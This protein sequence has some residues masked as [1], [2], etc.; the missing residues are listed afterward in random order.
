M[1]RLLI[2]FLV[3]A[4]G[5]L[6][7]MAADPSEQFLSAYQSYQ[8][9]EKAERDGNTTDALK[10]Y[11]YAESLLADIAAKDPSWQKAVV[12]YRLK[13]TRDG[14]T[15]LQGEPDAT[16]SSKGQEAMETRN[17]S[18]MTPP[19]SVPPEASP[20]PSP[21]G[22]SITILAPGAS[23]SQPQSSAESPSEVRR[24]K[25]QI[26]GLQSELLM[27]K[28]A[29]GSE[30]SRSRDLDKAK[31]VEERSGLE[32]ELLAAKDQI[33][34]L[35]EKLHARDSWDKDLKNL[36]KKLDEAVADS[37]VAD[38]LNQQREKA[39]AENTARLVGELSEANRKVAEAGGVQRNFLEMSK[40][41]ESDR[42][43]LKQ[44]QA[45]LD[46]TLQTAKDSADKNSNL[47]RQISEMSEKLAIAEKKS[48]DLNLLR[49]KVN[50]LQSKLAKANDD[51]EQARRS[52]QKAGEKLLG[53]LKAVDADR[54][55]LDE[56]CRTLRVKLNDLNQQAQ[57]N[58]RNYEASQRQLA[59]ITGNRPDLEKSLKEKETALAAAKSEAEKLRAELEASNQKISSLNK[60]SSQQE[61]HL[62]ELQD[63]LAELSKKPAGKENDAALATEEARQS[64]ED[65]RVSL[66]DKDQELARLR[67]LRGKTA[68]GEKILEENSVLRGIVMRQ[69]REEARKAQARRLMEEEMKRLNVQ[70][71]SLSENMALLAAP[72][73]SLTSKERALFKDAQLVFSSDDGKF[74]ASIA[75]P[76]PRKEELPSAVAN[77]PVASSGTTGTNGPVVTGNTNIPAGAGETNA[78]NP[79][80]TLSKPVVNSTNA[81]NA[82]PE[83]IAWQGKFKE[84]LARAKEEFDRQDYLQAETSFQ[85]ALKLSPEDYF[86]LS[87]LGVVEFQL[88]KMKEAEEVL[89]KA[90]KKSNDSSF[91]L[92]TLGIVHY[93]QGRL[94][95]AEKVLRRAIILNDQDF[96]AHNYLGI[97][98]A[99]SGNGKAGESEIMKAIEINQKYADAHFNLAVIY[100]TGKPPS[101]MMAKKHYAKAIELV[102]P[103]DASLEQ[104]IQ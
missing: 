91:A 18:D 21:R 83:E 45:R 53:Q 85:D 26:E 47:R 97:V 35:N 14:V 93:R 68:A 27:V 60:Q 78:T 87:N 10:K 20:K 57:S 31:W 8:Q 63:Q 3:F 101:K 67:K 81:T 41:V 89:M 28:E 98:L 54:L 46:Q 39:S 13:K 16:A 74:Q 2:T 48:G 40:E 25:K 86:A 32:K 102:A 92:T 77:A 33:A 5:M 73:S 70:S 71:E 82:V 42:E 79:P 94:P 100:A 69:V 66:K 12:E 23:S 51:S 29:L 103:P 50:S 22:P 76:M 38:E 88:G 61:D 104:L 59:E 17:D 55:V 80:G 37:L 9:A 65:L 56:E 6:P 34:T 44:L 49:D 19:E 90:T 1:M 64:A 72:G 15:R 11:R 84:C 95:D 43:A 4:G 52:S 58:A 75:A 36:Q 96:T 99:A 62:K 24:L 30:K 7:L